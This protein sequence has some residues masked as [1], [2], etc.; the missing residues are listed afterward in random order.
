MIRIQLDDLLDRSAFVIDED[1]EV[2]VPQQVKVDL[3]AV[4][5]DG[6]DECTMLVQGG[7]LVLQGKPVIFLPRNHE[8][9]IDKKYPQFNLDFT[10]KR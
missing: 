5:A 7:D 6:H 9:N 2:N 8:L 10:Q 3:I 1:F 4:V